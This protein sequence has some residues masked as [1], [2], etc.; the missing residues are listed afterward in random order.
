[1]TSYTEHAEES[2]FCSKK[3]KKVV[4]YDLTSEIP[5]NTDH[6]NLH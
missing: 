1:M 6:S 3:K 5:I 2:E 4:W